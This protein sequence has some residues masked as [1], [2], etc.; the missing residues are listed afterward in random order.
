[1]KTK[2]FIIAFLLAIALPLSAQELAF[3]GEINPNQFSGWKQLNAEPLGNGW[4]MALLENPDPNSSVKRIQTI[5]NPY[6]RYVSEYGW[7]QDGNVMA[8]RINGD[9][10]YVRYEYSEEEKLECMLCHSGKLGRRL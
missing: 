5:F 7:F 3:E 10:K 2:L 1:M 6:L 4:V 8:Y 9:G